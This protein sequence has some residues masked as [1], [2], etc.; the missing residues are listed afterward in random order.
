M[1]KQA[2]KISDFS[3]GLNSF[4]D[5]KDIQ[6]NEFQALDNA[7]VDENGIIRVSGGVSRD[8]VLDNISAASLLISIPCNSMSGYKYFNAL[9]FIPIL[10]PNSIQLLILV[11]A[12]NDFEKKFIFEARRFSP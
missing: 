8:I 3:G 9:R 6:N 4:S 5:S 1:S 12:F 2:L 7:E 10:A 11:A